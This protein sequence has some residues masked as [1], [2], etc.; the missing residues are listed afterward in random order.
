MG[1]TLHGARI[2]VCNVCRY[3]SVIPPDFAGD[4]VCPRCLY[5]DI[6]KNEPPPPWVA[7]LCT[8]AKI[9]ALFAA[10]LLAGIVIGTVYA[11][12]MG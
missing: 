5:E 7:T 1:H 2:H 10:A 4:P 9:S 8:T 3:W 11:R 6:L 12:V